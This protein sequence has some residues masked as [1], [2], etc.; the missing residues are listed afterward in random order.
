MR[1]AHLLVHIHFKTQEPRSLRILIVWSVNCGKRRNFSCAF[2]VLNPTGPS[3]LTR[4]QVERE[5]RRHGNDKERVKEETDPLLE[6]Q[7]LIKVRWHTGAYRV[8][9]VREVQRMC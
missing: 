6:T 5:A 7:S 2:R 9:C 4:K 8:V 3:L 1:N